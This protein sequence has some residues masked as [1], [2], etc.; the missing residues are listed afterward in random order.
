M[1]FLQDGAGHC[2]WGKVRNDEIRSQLGMRKLNKQM[3]KRKTKLPVTIS[4]D[5]I[6]KSSQTTFISTD[7]KT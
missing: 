4:E 1:L 7:R 6:R 2:L 3:H 5:A